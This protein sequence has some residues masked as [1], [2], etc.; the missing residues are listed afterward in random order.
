MKYMYMLNNIVFAGQS[1]VEMCVCA[2]CYIVKVNCGLLWNYFID[3]FNS[4]SVKKLGMIEI[5]PSIW[6]SVSQGIP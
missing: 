3:L 6:T 1:A 2:H 4:S 5:A